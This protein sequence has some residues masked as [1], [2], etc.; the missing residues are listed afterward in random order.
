MGFLRVCCTP[1]EEKVGYYCQSG[2]CLG[3][4]ETHILLSFCSQFSVNGLLF[5][6]LW[7]D[8]DYRPFT[9]N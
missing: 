2:T 1:K 8:V 9:E 5:Q 6:C 7:G 4:L 3:A